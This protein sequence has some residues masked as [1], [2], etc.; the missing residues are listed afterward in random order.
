MKHI[1]IKYWGTG[2]SYSL[3]GVTYICRHCHKMFKNTIVGIVP[4]SYSIKN[5]RLCIVYPHNVCKCKSTNGIE[6]AW[7]SVPEN[8]NDPDDFMFTIAMQLSMKE[9]VNKAMYQ[10]KREIYIDRFKE[11]NYG[12]N[13]E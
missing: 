9:Y 7:I 1:G 12:D 2:D 10:Y 8:K 11:D 13:D 4:T 5:D 3:S 6:L